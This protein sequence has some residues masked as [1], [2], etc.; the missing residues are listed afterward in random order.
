LDACAVSQVMNGPTVALAANLNRA[1]Y[2]LSTIAR[3]VL[4]LREESAAAILC[5]LQQARHTGSRAHSR[6]CSV[7]VPATPAG[8]TAL[9]ARTTGEASSARL[10]IVLRKPSAVLIEARESL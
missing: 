3:C 4:R 8:C 10:W 1:L 5:S 7:P 9:L 6:T 2:G